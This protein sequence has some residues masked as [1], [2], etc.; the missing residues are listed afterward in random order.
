MVLYC[1]LSVIATQIRASHRN[2]LQTEQ[3]TVRR[4]D[5]PGITADFFFFFFFSWSQQGNGDTA[6]GQLCRHDHSMRK[7]TSNYIGLRDTHDLQRLET[8]FTVSLGH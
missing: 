1:T 2:H 5:A 6:V 8:L 7:A 4:D 3:C